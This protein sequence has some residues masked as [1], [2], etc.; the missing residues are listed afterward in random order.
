MQRTVEDQKQILAKI[1]ALKTKAGEFYA[2][3][4]VIE[5]VEEQRLRDLETR[6]FKATIPGGHSVVIDLTEGN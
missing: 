2:S 4:I 5:A 6:R 1:S 3:L